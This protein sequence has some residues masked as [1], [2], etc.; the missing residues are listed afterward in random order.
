MRNEHFHSPIS[1]GSF[2]CSYLF[3]IIDYQMCPNCSINLT[4]YRVPKT[5]KHKIFFRFLYCGGFSS[6]C[7]KAI[8]KVICK[9]FCDYLCFIKCKKGK[10]YTSSSY[11]FPGKYFPMYIPRHTRY[12]IHP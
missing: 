9:I 5:V 11:I 1:N 8:I 10:I 4:K 6:F 12:I 3:A 2:H 7:V